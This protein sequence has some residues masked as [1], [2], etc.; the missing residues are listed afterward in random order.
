MLIRALAGVATR[1]ER[2][3]INDVRWGRVSP[4]GA[5][6]F[7]N[8]GEITGLWS[9]GCALSTSNPL[10]EGETVWLRARSELGEL[11]LSLVGTVVWAEH[12]HRSEGYHC[13]V[14]FAVP[15]TDPL[16]EVH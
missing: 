3:R 10:R 4:R 2:C 1:R 13:E 8:R 14:R 7:S 15:G 11:L 9:A 12:V 6:G 5:P 16:N